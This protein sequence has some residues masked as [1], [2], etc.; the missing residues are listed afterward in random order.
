VRK[1]D[2]QFFANVSRHEVAL[3]RHQRTALC[4]QNS[5]CG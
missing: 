2:E 1:A 3:G 5:I 4:L